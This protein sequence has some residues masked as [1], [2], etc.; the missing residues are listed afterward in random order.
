MTNNTATATATPTVIVT[1]IATAIVT[2]IVTAPHPH[3]TLTPPSPQ[4]TAR[5]AIPDSDIPA[6]GTLYKAR[7]RSDT[8]QRSKAERPGL[9]AM[10]MD[11]DLPLK[12]PRSRIVFVQSS[13]NGYAARACI[14]KRRLV[15][16]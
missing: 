14:G 2:A 7:A 1:A 6:T 5:E 4:R 13:T 3:S 15:V 11:V 16:A 9:R 10:K 8:Q 12:V